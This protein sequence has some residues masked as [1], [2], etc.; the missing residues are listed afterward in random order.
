M[1]EDGREREMDRSTTLKN[2]E[3]LEIL[4]QRNIC[5]G[6]DDQQQSS[7]DRCD[8]NR[9]A[10]RLRINEIFGS[11]DTPQ[12]LSICILAPSLENTIPN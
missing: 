11:S 4:V 9:N 2:V 5:T 10:L 12:N 3:G 7:R 6:H 1:G 8:R